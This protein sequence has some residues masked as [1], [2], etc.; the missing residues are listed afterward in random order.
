MTDVQ[1]P[2]RARVLFLVRVPS[3]RRGAFLA[4]YEQIRHTVANGVPGHLVDQVC[5]ASADSEQWLI[6]SEWESLAAFSAWE[7][8]PGHR[9]L[10]K[11]LRDCITE[12]RSEQFLIHAE[13]RRGAAAHASTD[14]FSDHE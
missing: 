4:A 11:P 7:R 13:T 6:T 14:H 1:P 5:Q 9:D 3:D 12:R 2:P 8:S 10:V